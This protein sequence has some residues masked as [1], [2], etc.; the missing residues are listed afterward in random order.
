[1]YELGEQVEVAQGGP[2]GEQKGIKQFFKAS[3]LKEGQVVEGVYKGTFESKK[4]AG[5]FFH[6]FEDKAGDVYAY[7][8]SVAIND[9][10]K[11]IKEAAE[12]NDVLMYAQFTYQGKHKN[13]SNPKKTTHRFSKVSFFKTNVPKPVPTAPAADHTASDIPF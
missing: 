8:E 12:A 2:Q 5:Y 13:K 9:A 10:I 7:G 4:T 11:V 3:D 6:I 1:M